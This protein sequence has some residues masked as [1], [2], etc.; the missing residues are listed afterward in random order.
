MRERQRKRA[1]EKVEDSK[2][3]VRRKTELGGEISREGKVER[4]R[5]V[6]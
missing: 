2:S 4:D 3:T 5:E 1:K 6:G